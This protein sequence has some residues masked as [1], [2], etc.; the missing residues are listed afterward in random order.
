MAA[1]P[2][3]SVVVPACGRIATLRRCMAALAAQQPVAGGLEVVVSIDG[4]DPDAAAVRAEAPD[5]L[6][7]TVLEAPRTGPAGAR[8]RGAAAASAPLVAFV[9]DDCEP[10]PGWAAALEAALAREPGALVGGPVVNANPRDSAA[11]ASHAV[12]AALYDSE[13]FLA[14]SNLALRAETFAALGGFDESFPTPAGEDRDLCDRAAGRGHPVVHVSAAPALHHRPSSPGALWRQYAEYGRGGRRLTRR[15][16]ENGQPPV[17]AGRGFPRALARS[18]L[19]AAREAR[20]P[21][22]VLLVGLTQAA[23][24]WG[25]ATTKR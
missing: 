12:L 3:I 4:P 17:R 14:S 16:A 10:A 1:A 19:R 21:S 6:R 24:A 5:G 7:L 13:P 23:T 11:A 18:T 25:Y 8:N 22:V 15:R 9:D 2:G 20:S